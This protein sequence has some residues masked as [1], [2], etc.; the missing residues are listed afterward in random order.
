MHQVQKK[1][2]AL[3]ATQNLA[4]LKLREI[5]ELVQEPHPQ[6]I[7]HHINQLFKKGFLKENADGTIIT[8]VDQFNPDDKFIALPIL[9]SAN[10]GEA[11]IFAEQN[12]E[13]Y[14]HVSKS[15]IPNYNSKEMFVIKAVGDSMNKADIDGQSID[16]GD[17][18][19]I[20]RR[21]SQSLKNIN[22]KY[23]LSIINGM[24]NIKK[25]IFDEVRNRILLLSESTQDYAPIIINNNDF[26]N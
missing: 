11:L 21:I 2:L 10:C 3:S 12:F 5:G 16:D 26:D 25:F 4:S 13:G 19:V 20:D 1:I 17:F 6:K 7:K 14:L 8:R 15:F 23:V 24:A 9:G 18:L 22:M